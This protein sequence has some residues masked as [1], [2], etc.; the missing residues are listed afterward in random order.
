MPHTSERKCTPSW[1]DSYLD[2]TTNQESPTIFHKWVG[3]AIVAATMERHVVLDMGAYR[4]FPN[5]YT[6]LV[7]D[8]ALCKKTTAMDMGYDVLMMLKNKVNVFAQKITPEALIARLASQLEK[9]DSGR[10]IRDCVSLIFA[11]ELSVF[12]GTDAYKSGLVS[13]LTELFQGRDEWSYETR[14][15]GEEKLQ[16]TLINFFGASTPRWLKIGIPADQAGGGFTSRIVFVYSDKPRPPI[17]F[18]TIDKAHQAKL[19]HDLNIIRSLKGKFKWNV[20]AKEWYKHWYKSKGFL[21]ISDALS[22]YQYRKH[23]L[24]LKVAMLLSLCRGN[25]LELTIDCLED[26]LVYVNEVEQDAT[27]AIEAIE[28]TQTGT[29]TTRVYEY[30]QKRGDVPRSDLT[31]AFSHR[32]RSVELHEILETLLDAD[33]IDVK[34]SRNKKATRGK[35]TQKVYFATDAVD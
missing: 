12:L 22:G 34:E 20:D 1:I 6:V 16:N 9:S 11:P 24:L 33:L 2:Y 21:P 25:K 28:E 31:R 26:G 27:K 15:H 8:S 3:L 14:L 4:L 32:L 18:P 10:I 23:D 7:S 5:L 30:I 29:A 35:Q 17:P 13:I 19:A